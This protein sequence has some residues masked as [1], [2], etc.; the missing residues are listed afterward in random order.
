MNYD[1]LFFEALGEEN[2]HLTEEMEKKI[3]VEY[4]PLLEQYKTSMSELFFCATTDCK[5]RTI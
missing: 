1:I 5:Q 3:P 2:A 4:H